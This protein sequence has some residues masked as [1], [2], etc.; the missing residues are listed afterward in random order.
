MVKMGDGVMGRI[1][2]ALLFC[3]I[4][5][6]AWAWGEH[7]LITHAAL[8]KVTDV[9]N[10]SVVVTDFSELLSKLEISSPLEFN[11]KIQIKK[12]YVF[13]HKFQDEPGKTVS[14]MDVLSNYSDEP[15]WGMDIE[16]FEADQY[17]EIWKNEY[18]MMGGKK[19]TPSQAFRHMYWP[20]DLTHPISSFK[21]PKIFTSMGTAPDRAQVFV[22]LARQAHAVGEDYWALRFLAN[23]LHYLEDCSSLFHSTQTPTKAF[24]L[25][26][27][28]SPYG[29]KEKQFVTQVTHIVTYYHFAF[30]GYIGRLMT[31]GADDFTVPLM[32]TEN[33]YK[34]ILYTDKNPAK[35]IKAMSKLSMVLAAPAA[36]ASIKFFPEIT[37]PF[38]TLDADVFMDA[39]WWAKT[40]EQGQADTEAKRTYFKLVKSIFEPQGY[41]V[42]NLV[43]AETQGW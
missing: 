19:G 7:H 17:P 9:T 10:K 2:L 16:L 40:M 38:N 41:G 6:T 22:G 3:F 30:E 25:M 32:S 20:A 15:D 1:F 42:R 37:V 31:A 36:K 13:T 43:N 23:S 8:S 29:Q 27:F 39:A 5:K 26:P 18:S 33:V 34:S 12:Q 4:P 35:L 24:M 28:T 21:L 14:A 11:T